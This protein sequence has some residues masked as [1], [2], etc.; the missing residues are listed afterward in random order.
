MPA[1]AKVKKLDARKYGELLLSILPR[2]IRNEAE[3]D[4]VAA[5]VTRLALKGENALTPEEGALLDLLTM[6][7][8]R[9]DDENHLIPDAPPD[10]VIR[11]LMQDRGLRHKDLVPVLGSRGATSDVINGKR[12]PS[13]TQVMAL[14]AFFK[15]SPEVFIFLN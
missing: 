7:I 9:Y 6:L 3:Y 10:A 11:M 1:N 4:R 13:K 15:V 12:P 2:P 5:I 8:E 14:A